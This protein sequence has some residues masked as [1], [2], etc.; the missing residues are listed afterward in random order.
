MLSHSHHQVFVQG[1]GDEF[2]KRA[3]EALH[4]AVRF[5]LKH[6]LSGGRGRAWEARRP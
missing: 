5:R 4:G 3:A 6:A 1:E 2:A